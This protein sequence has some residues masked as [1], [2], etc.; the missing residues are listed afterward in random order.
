VRLVKRRFH[1]EDVGMVVNDL[2]VNHFATYVDYD[3]TSQMEDRLDQIARGEAQWKPL[4]REFWD[5]F[6]ARIGQKEKEIQKS[7]VTTEQTEEQCPQCQKPLVIKLGRYGRFYACSGFPECRY[8]RSL[9]NGNDDAEADGQ[10]TTETCPQCGSP[11][12]PRQG[13]Y[14]A[15]LG[16][17]KYPACKYIQPRNKPV[18]LGV[19]CPDCA[20]GEMQEKKTR[21]GKIFYSCSNYPKCS[22]ASWDKPL[23]E[24]CPACGHGFLVE[25]KSKR[26]GHVIACP[27]KQCSY[28]RAVAAHEQPPEDHEPTG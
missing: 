9:K 19:H 1:P 27:N 22:F 14:G 12:M 28:R 17:S 25:K 10:P 3:F 24:P 4:V 16:C 11:L 8:V 7:A 20:D 5:P 23:A 18:P 13:R 6:I 26:Y 21:K 15:F 2:L